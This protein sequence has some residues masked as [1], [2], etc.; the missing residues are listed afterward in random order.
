MDSAIVLPLSAIIHTVL[1][2]RQLQA[3][4]H[5]LEVQ[6]HL[7]R[8][9]HLQILVG[10][11]RV[12]PQGHLGHRGIYGD[13][14]IGAALGEGQLIESI[15]CDG[16]AV[17]IG[18]QSVLRLLDLEEGEPGAAGDA[19]VGRGSH[20]Y[21][22]FR[23]AREDAILGDGGNALVAHRPGHL[24]LFW[25]QIFLRPHN[26]FQI[27]DM[28]HQGRALAGVY[29]DTLRLEAA[30]LQGNHI[31]ERLVICIIQHVQAAPYCAQLL[32]IGEVKAQ[33]DC[34]ARLISLQHHA[35]GQGILLCFVHQ[36]CSHDEVVVG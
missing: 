19:I 23:H 1:G 20:Q 18:N 13:V 24:P 25:G 26:G 28:P 5:I 9:I 16:V 21:A 11:I 12:T 33:L 4:V 22:S 32:G 15:L 35:L 31:A 7:A 27:P 29:G 17:S 30:Q 8:A 3:D 2:A 34:L 36:L 6:G 10:D 14:N